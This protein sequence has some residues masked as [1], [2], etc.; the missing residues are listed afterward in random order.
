MAIEAPEHVPS[1]A[2]HNPWQFSLRRMFVATTALAML[3]GLAKWGGWIESDA[4]VY[5]AIAVLAAVFWRAARQ[6]L[7]GACTI[8]GAAWLVLVLSEVSF[9]SSSGRGCYKQGVWIFS[10][11]LL[12]SS[13]VFLR[14]VVRVP[15]WRLVGSLV[16]IELFITAIIVYTYGCS[17]LLQALATE[18][19]E[20]VVDH[21]LM[22]FPEQRWYIAAPWLLGIVVGEAVVRRRKSGGA[23]PQEV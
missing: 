23:P 21:F 12:F 16:L 5:L 3:F 9:G 7:L 8:L 4:V 17:T 14:V 13:A 2:Q 22:W 6:A 1:V 19:R 15:V 18:Y 20:G 10:P 11:L